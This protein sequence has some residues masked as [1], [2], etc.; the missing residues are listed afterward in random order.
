MNIY[1]IGDLHLTTD[2]SKTMDKFGWTGHD[3]RIFED[4]N[5]KVTGDDVVLIAGDISWA[6]KFEQALP[7]LERIHAQKGLKILVKG[8][9]DYWW[10][11]ITRLNSL[12]EDMFFLQNNIKELDSVV[13]AGS[14]LWLAP[15]DGNY[16]DED[17][18]IYRREQIRL[19]NSLSLA[20]KTGKEIILLTHFPPANENLDDNP[21]LHIVENYSVSHMIYGHLHGKTA[22]KTALKGFRNGTYFHLVSCDYTDFKLLKIASF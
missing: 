18:K 2:E 8:N 20:K 11:S 16:S 3:R 21:V 5:E 1:A 7:D 22:H 13:I 10:D 19:E 14:R 12:Y 15:N 6:M 17:E 4:W 9:H